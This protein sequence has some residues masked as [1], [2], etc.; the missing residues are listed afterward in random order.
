MAQRFGKDTFYTEFKS[1]M[2]YHTNQENVPKHWEHLL[3]KKSVY[4]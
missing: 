2:S 3:T 4:Q 1:K